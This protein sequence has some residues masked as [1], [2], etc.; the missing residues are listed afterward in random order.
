MTPEHYLDGSRLPTGLTE[1]VLD[2]TY[3]SSQQDLEGV[4]IPLRGRHSKLTTT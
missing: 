1:N 2:H 3:L 4:I